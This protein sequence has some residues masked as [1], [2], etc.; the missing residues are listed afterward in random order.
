MNI[1]H[2]PLYFDLYKNPEDNDE[3][4]Y[5]YNGLYFDKERKERDWSRLPDIFS[6]KIPD[7][8]EAAFKKK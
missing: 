1:E 6:E 3:L 4:Y 8:V 2:K 7:E 5:R